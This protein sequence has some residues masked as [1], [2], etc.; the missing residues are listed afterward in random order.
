METRRETPSSIAVEWRVLSLTESR[1]HIISY[2][3]DYG[4][5]FGSCDNVL[6]LKSITTSNVSI[7]LDDLDVQM[8]YCVRVAAKTSIGVGPR[9]K[10]A[11]VNGM[12]FIHMGANTMFMVFLL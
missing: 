5:T 8:D 12:A 11:L 4:V 6:P 9:S 1:G 3:V 7:L 2:A 10:L